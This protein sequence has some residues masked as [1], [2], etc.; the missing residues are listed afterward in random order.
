MIPLWLSHSFSTWMEEIKLVRYEMW[1]V[2]RNFL[3]CSAQLSRAERVKISMLV[4]V[5]FLLKLSMMLTA[6]KARIRYSQNFFMI[7]FGVVLHCITVQ[8]NTNL[9]SFW[10]S[11]KWLSDL[12]LNLEPFQSNR[13]V[14]HYHYRKQALTSNMLNI[15]IG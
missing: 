9:I 5:C 8:V 10:T 3:L 15:I 12:K 7:I 1:M 4:T 14:E 6:F 2:L 11:S 13:T